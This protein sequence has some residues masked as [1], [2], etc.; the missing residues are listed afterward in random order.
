VTAVAVKTANVKTAVE[1]PTSDGSKV[2]IDQL[3][4]LAKDVFDCLLLSCATN[5][6]T[7]DLV[8]GSCSQSKAYVILTVSTPGN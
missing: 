7:G 5:T 3:D 6:S 1:K 8:S 4:G 2:R